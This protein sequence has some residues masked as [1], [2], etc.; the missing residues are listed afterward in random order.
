[1]RSPS[2]WS[3]ALEHEERTATSD[4]AA[5]APAGIPGIWQTGEDCRDQFRA[6]IPALLGREGETVVAALCST[7]PGEGTTS[8]VAG[9]ACAAA[10]AE[11]QVAVI[12]GH[13]ERPGQTR[14]FWSGWQTDAPAP[15]SAS[16]P[17]VK[18]LTVFGALAIGDHTGLHRQIDTA[19]TRARL[20]LLDLPPIKESNRVLRMAG[21][22]DRLYLVVEAERERREA[23]ARSV[24]SLLRAQLP[25]SG[26]LLNKR[27]RPIPGALYRRL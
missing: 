22:A 24:Q 26:V 25:L 23:I 20:V 5:C 11:T 19:R 17:W 2:E 3:V 9:L 21:R 7:L 12:D 13:A 10:E 4:P 8:L 18:R 15:P 6:L 27:T 1:V 16:E 14:A